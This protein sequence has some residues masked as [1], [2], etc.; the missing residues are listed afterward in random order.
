M[1]LLSARRV[2]ALTTVTRDARGASTGRGGTPHRT[3]FLCALGSSPVPAITTATAFTAQFYRQL[4]L[5]PLFVESVALRALRRIE[6]NTTSAYLPRVTSGSVAWV[7][8]ASEIPD[9]G[10]GVDLL[11]VT[12]RKV[13]ALAIV[14]NEATG[15]ANAA[16]MLGQALARAVAVEVDRA[17]FRGGGTNGPAGL[18]GVAGVVAV[19]ADPTSGLDPWTDAVA[20]VESNGARATVGFVS[21]TTWAALS[22]VKESTGSNKPVLADPATGPTGEVARSIGGLPVLVSASIANGEA[23]VVDGSRVAAVVRTD[24]EVRAD[25]SARFTSDSTVVRVISRV[26]FGVPYP[27]SVVRIKV[28]V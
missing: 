23:W 22:K 18:P 3:H 19:N 10:A 26:G 17:L 28:T 11:A 5:E 25:T 20:A 7:P 14:S 2:V 13:A 4:I 6:I 1:I 12:P 24:G 15:D 27:G 16:E 21:P 8:E 9:S